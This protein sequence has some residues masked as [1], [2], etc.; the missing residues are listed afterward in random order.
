MNWESDLAASLDNRW[1]DDAVVDAH[2]YAG[3][4]YDWLYEHGWR[5]STD[6]TARPSR[7]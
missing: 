4:T 6:V 7:L 3:F 1:T 5:G 2:A